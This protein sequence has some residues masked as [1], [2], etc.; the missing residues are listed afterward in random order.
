MRLSPTA[1]LLGA[2]T[3]GRLPE[4]GTNVVTS[5]VLT[6]AVTGWP[7]GWIDDNRLL[8]N[9]YVSGGIGNPTPSFD[10]TEI[11][12]AA[13]TLVASPELPEVFNLQRVSTNAIYSRDL[14]Q[15][16]DVTTGA[17]VWSSS[18]DHFSEGAVAGNDVIFAA[19]GP[20]TVRVEP[21]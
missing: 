6:T 2:A 16:L 9:R 12:N 11:R 13:G 8:L 19:R 10:G 1:T 3:T 20:A 17:T 5:G 21:R 7:V 18:T 4:A 14:N 15:I